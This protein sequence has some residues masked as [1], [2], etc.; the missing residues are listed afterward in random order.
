MFP[1]TISLKQKFET[2]KGDLK[3]L[4]SSLIKV[5][6]NSFKELNKS[7]SLSTNQINSE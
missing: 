5:N 2:A 3:E 7:N 6:L 1:T 4:S